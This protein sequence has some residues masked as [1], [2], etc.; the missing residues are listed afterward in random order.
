MENMLS[1]V[2]EKGYSW[3]TVIAEIIEAVKNNVAICF[4]DYQKD[5]EKIALDLSNRGVK[6]RFLVGGNMQSDEKRTAS[7]AF[8]SGEDNVLVATETYECG[9]H[10][11]NCS[12]VI[13]IGCA[14]NCAVIVQELG[15]VGRNREN[16]EFNY[17]WNEFHDDQRLANWVKPVGSRKAEIDKED[18]EVKVIIHSFVTSWR[19]LYS[20]LIGMCSHQALSTFFDDSAD[21]L[22]PIQHCKVEGCMCDSCNTDHTLVD[23]SSMIVTMLVALKDALQYE[24]KFT[25]RYFSCFLMQSSI[26][27]LR[28]RTDLVRLKSFGCAA[29]WPNVSMEGLFNLIRICI[30]LGYINL[31]YDFFS[32]SDGTTRS[33]RRLSLSESGG[34][35]CDNIH[36]VTV[37]DPFNT[38][39][40]KRLK[41]NKEK[42]N[43]R[44]ISQVGLPVVKR[45]LKEPEK[46]LTISDEKQYRALG[47]GGETFPF[48]YYVESWKAMKAAST[49]DFLRNDL[50]MTKGSGQ[51]AQKCSHEV[52]IRDETEKV[53][54]KINKCKGCKKCPVED[55]YVGFTNYA[56][57]N[58]CVVHK[59]DHRT[60][61]TCGDNCPVSF[62]YVYPKDEADLRQWFGCV[63]R[64]PTGYNHPSPIDWKLM[65]RTKHD[66]R[67]AQILN[68]YGK[69]KDFQKGVGME[70]EPMLVDPAATHSG[71]ISRELSRT[72]GIVGAGKFRTL[73]ILENF[74][75]IRVDIEKKTDPELVHEET[76]EELDK[77]MGTYAAKDHCVM[78][79]DQLYGFF[80]A[81]WQTKCL[82]QATHIFVDICYIRNK[83]LPGLL[84]I[85]APCA[86][87]KCYVPVYRIFLN[88]QDAAAIAFVIE[89][90]FKNVDKQYSQFKMGSKLSNSWLTSAT[91]KKMDFVSL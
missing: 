17:L 25:M 19:F 45:M 65:S 24:K 63:S 69:P 20:H 73:N 49:R 32:L 53:V 77:E 2:P 15:R 21:D 8:K 1:T 9:M 79:G 84:N 35:Y 68:P 38:G 16:G 46:W 81:N 51:S 31:D 88:K 64:K 3:S 14:R 13:R 26:K 89:T 66:I 22:S 34:E 48:L 23:V 6:A 39:D 67:A 28:E 54:I 43:R 7:N 37:P 61:V 62:I 41:D 74:N 58:E 42:K 75:S 5:A 91:L 27:W 50:Q 70:Y 87:L 80:A 10:N 33:Y 86:E 78:I 71:R 59:N 76:K 18:E 60:V 36:K 40:T 29:D 85:V 57:F 56:R 72:V 11:E 44:S 90:T 82:S 30:C 83:E 47:F 12:K 4:V 55:C 52:K